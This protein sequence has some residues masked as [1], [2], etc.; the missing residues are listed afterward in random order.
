MLQILDPGHLRSGHQVTWTYARGVEGAPPWGFQ[1]SA[2]RRP[3]RAKTP[4]KASETHTEVTKS[5]RKPTKKARPDTQGL[6]D[7]LGLPRK[8]A[9]LKNRA[10]LSIRGPSEYQDPSEHQAS[11]LSNLLASGGPLSHQGT[12]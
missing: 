6:S 2:G 4:A 7:H 12:L 9:H 8:R 11:D 3:A 5:V 1:A 10:P